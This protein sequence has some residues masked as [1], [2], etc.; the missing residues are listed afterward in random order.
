MKI[1]KF[2]ITVTDA[3]AEVRTVEHPQEKTETLPEELILGPNR[4][5]KASS[6]KGRIYRVNFLLCSGYS[7]AQA[8][9]GWVT[10]RIRG[11]EV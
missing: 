9:S 6:L 3:P 2:L 11:M 7:R 5:Y 4:S 8:I 1:N 10:P